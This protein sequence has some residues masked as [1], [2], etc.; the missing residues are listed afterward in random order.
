MTFFSD[1]L[2][3]LAADWVL[4]SRALL[5]VVS[6]L[7]LGLFSSQV[8]AAPREGVRVFLMRGI[9][10][11]STGLDDLAAKLRRRGISASVT[12]HTAASQVASDALHAYESR[13]GTKIVLIGHSLGANAS[14]H[15][16]QSLQEIGTVIAHSSPSS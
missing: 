6:T 5:L 13:P 3:R 4:Q 16:A 9:F 1:R 11:V 12:S 10:D 2:H 14:I 15:V 7:I 8:G